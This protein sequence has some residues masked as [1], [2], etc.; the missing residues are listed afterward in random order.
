MNALDLPPELLEQTWAGLLAVQRKAIRDAARRGLRVLKTPEP[1]TLYEWAQKHFYLSAESSQN[2]TRWNAYPYQRGILCAMGDDHIEEVD[3]AK[4]ARVGYALALDTPIPTPAG[5]TT[6]GNLKPGD[7]VF[8]EK[9]VPCRVQYASATYTDHDCYRIKFCDGTTVVADAGHRWFVQADLSIEYLLG[10]RGRG[11]VGR[12]K[13]G[14]SATFEGVVETRQLAVM[15]RTARGRSAIAVPVCQPLRLTAP[16]SLP[17]PPYTLGL[18]LGDGH[19]VTPRITQHR[20]DIETADHIRS[21]G[22]DA[23]VRYIDSRNPDNATIFLDVPAT[24][25]PV[26]PW[27]SVFRTHGL[28]A[29]K[30]I[31]PAYLRA[32]AVTRLQLLR[33][34]MDS[35][36]T[37]GADGRAE[38][39]NTNADLAHGVHELL[40]SLG[41]K[42]SQRVRLA[43]LTGHLTQYRINFKP[44]PDCNPFLLARKAAMVKAAERP[45]ITHRRR[46]VSV[47]P[48][49]SVP[50]RC[51]QVDSPSSLFLCTKAM[52]PTHN[53][54][55]FLAFVGY[56]HAHKRR[57]GCVWQPTDADSDEFCKAE[58]EPM[59]R[60]V[61]AM[62]EVFPAFMRKSKANTLNMKKFLG[63]MLY[64][65]GGTSAG[66]Y[67]RM[68][69]QWFCADEFSGFDDKI[70]GSADPWTLMWK[71]LEGA[72]Y[73]KAI[74]G[75][76]MR[77]K[78]ADHTE[79][80]LNAALVRMSYQ[81]P[82]PHCGVEHPLQWGGAGVRH[83]FKWDPADPEGTVHHVCPHC[84]GRMTQD[85]YLTIWD[86]GVWVS[87]CGNYR[88]YALANGEYYWTDGA[89]C[90][91]TVPP[92]HVGIRVWTAY[93]PQTEWAVIVREW[94]H[95][96][97]CAKKGDKGPL[98]GF[99]NETLGETWKE[100]A[101]ET[102][103]HELKRRAEA[104]PLRRV[105]V[106][107]LDLVASVDTQDKWWA[108]T[109]L[110]IGRHDEAWVVDY[111]ELSGDPG[112][113]GDWETILYPYLQTTFH[114][115]LGAPMRIS[116]AGIDTGGNHTH[117]VYGFCRK[118]AAEKYFA[119]KGDS[120]EAKPIKGKATWVDVNAKGR[121]LKKG[122][123][124]WWV[125]TD[126]AKD[127]IFARLQLKQPGPGYI[128]FSRDLPTAY[129]EGLT[130]EV[131]RKVRTASGLKQRWVK[132]RER[133]EPLDTMV[134]ALWVSQA[135]D[136]HK[137]TERMWQR[138]EQALQPDLFL[139]TD[140][141]LPSHSG[142][143]SAAPP[144][145]VP[146]AEVPEPAGAPT[147]QA[148][149]A[150]DRPAPP[151]NERLPATETQRINLFDIAYGH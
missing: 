34:L 11:R 151:R 123:K 139:P 150:V 142:P 4:S 128:H 122:V 36:G 103:S 119:L 89:G 99:V 86:H 45:S 143:A 73:K 21:E 85:V 146:A 7:Q 12:P 94:L 141:L 31:P 84:H 95:A 71:R 5:W 115:W 113:E 136:H 56:Q 15:Q 79:R 114:H 54:K 2:E 80:R 59:L 27:A 133:N 116:G 63:S 51:I 3:V 96:I 77:I 58:L 126:T 24:G 88:L 49:A 90:R 8:D 30:H 39:V 110:A 92:R 57:N 60:D 101:D 76:T 121:I 18:W 68:T 124:L 69:L 131:R 125:G 53:T 111:V 108:V 50:V 127:L 107:G 120:Q 1:M 148:P 48:V 10:Q 61:K 17:I 134:Y 106:G 93:S 91:L 22:I 33:G 129:Y 97:E 138:L 78:D 105:P 35:D 117:Q 100:E 9:G 81:L 75:S 87:D 43:R 140:D 98:E 112:Q 132:V 40:A 102:D 145:D 109:V 25:R 26:S 6:M 104:Y 74:V 20:L 65:K 19:R 14:E 70:E 149:P 130:S 83:G 137:F 52:V 67:R 46:I 38:F 47:E 82:C 147:L 64:L 62:A 23:V 28:V 37:I 55:M 72:N 44:T 118:H 29:R 66:N 41:I 135:L 13:P 42:A 144:I 16:Q 32:D